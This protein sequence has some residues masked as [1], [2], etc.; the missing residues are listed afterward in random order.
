MRSKYSGFLNLKDW[1][2]RN[3]RFLPAEFPPPFLRTDDIGVVHDYFSGSDAYMADI[4]QSARTLDGH[5]FVCAQ[6]VGFQIDLPL[7]GNPVNWRETLVCSSCTL[8]NRWRACLHLFEAVCE[9]TL[10]DRIYLT[11]TLSPVHEQLASRFPNLVSS[12]FMSGAVPG[13]LVQ[14][15]TAEVRN[16]DVTRLTFRNRSFDS[17]LSFDVLE[18]VPDYHAALKEFH[19]VLRRGGKLILSVPFSFNQ[20]NVVRAELDAAGEI[21]H[22]LEPCYHGDP[23]SDQGVLSY[24]DFGMELLDEMR[25]VGFKE[26]TLVYYRSREWGYLG[27]NIAYVAMK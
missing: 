12:E 14:T 19:R 2:G 17:V 7:D 11:E 8:I 27:G 22:F 1:F 5:C 20:E 18:H 10:K 21:T 4:T 24:Y 26:S 3:K 15:H 16:E 13:S 25:H 6:D 23:L 9:P